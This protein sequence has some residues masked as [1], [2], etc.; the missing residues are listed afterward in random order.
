[1]CGTTEARTPADAEA[2]REVGDVGEHVAAPPPVVQAGGPSRVC[3]REEE[4]AP[5]L[6]FRQR[7][8]LGEQPLQV[9]LH[10][11]VRKD[12]HRPAR[13]GLLPA[14]ELGHDVLVRGFEEAQFGRDGGQHVVVPDLRATKN[15]A[16]AP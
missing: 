13:E 10:P 5:P 15:A 6:A 11:A 9:P 8:Q 7:Q 12:C 14:D 2:P 3:G 1:V 16:R 4:V